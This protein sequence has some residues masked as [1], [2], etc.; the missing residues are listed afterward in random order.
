MAPATEAEQPSPRVLPDVRVVEIASGVAVAYATQL[1]WQLGAEVIRIEPP[2]GDAVR[3]L[4][5]TAQ[6]FY[7]AFSLGQ[8][9]RHIAS[10]DSSGVAL[11]AIQ[12]LYGLVQ[13]K[14]TQI[15]ALEERL[16]ELEQG[17]STGAASA[18]PASSGLPTTWLLLGGLVVGALALGQ[19]ARK[20]VFRSRA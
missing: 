8:D 12:G 14:D 15:V 5:P 11:A 19:L 2:E 6:D 17:A 20:T 3:H 9:D 18:S 7:R 16:D 10:L 1:L 4:G 13:E